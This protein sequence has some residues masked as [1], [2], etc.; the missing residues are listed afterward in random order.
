[1]KRL[2]LFSAAALVSVAA[3][4]AESPVASV[5]GG[6]PFLLRGHSVPEGISNWPVMVGDSIGTTT[7]RSAVVQ[8]N[9]GSRVTL[10]PNSTGKVEQGANSLVFRLQTGSATFAQSS[11]KSVS[12][13][14]QDVPVTTK[15]VAPVTVMSPRVTAAPVTAATPG[16]P[17]GSPFRRPLSCI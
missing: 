2:L 6:E 16:S 10:A 8:F 14:V 13:F 1:M 12:M 3:L 9:D 15:A 17:C 7:S 4:F 11:A 5:T